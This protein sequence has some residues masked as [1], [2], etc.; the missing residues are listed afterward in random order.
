MDVATS[1]GMKDRA[2]KS[3]GGPRIE[4]RQL[5][6]MTAR[7]RVMRT[8]YG[9]L[10]MVVGLLVGWC[11][12]DFARAQDTE[13]IWRLDEQV[14]KL[15]R[16]RRYA[17]AVEIAERSLSMAERR[18]GFAHPNIA[19][20]VANLGLA[21]V[22]VSRRADAERVFR[23]CVAL[24]DEEKAKSDHTLTALVQDCRLLTSKP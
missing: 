11:C 3:F 17:E 4:A 8:T 22:A 15:F 21:Y 24:F 18:W 19:R 12:V 13:D 16:D 10:M 5:P 2:S 1:A 6:R 23:R 14:L 20:S 9:S 7:L